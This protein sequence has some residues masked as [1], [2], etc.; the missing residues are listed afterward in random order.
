[1]G[2]FSKPRQVQV[3]MRRSDLVAAQLELTEP[4]ANYFNVLFA[5]NSG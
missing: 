2:S 5:L 1:M 4:L 3:A